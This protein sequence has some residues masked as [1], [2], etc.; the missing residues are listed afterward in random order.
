QKLLRQLYVIPHMKLYSFDSIMTNYEPKLK[1]AEAPPQG[2]MPVSIVEDRSRLGSLV[3]K[4]FGQNTKCLDQRLAIGN[5]EAV[6]VE[7]SEHPLMRV[8]SIT[9]SPLQPPMNVT[10]LGTDCRGSRHSS[11][12]VEPKVLLLA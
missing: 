10:K 12:D 5:I 11:V 9:I 8:E 7:V 6:T 2:Y 4:I 3:T 1:Q